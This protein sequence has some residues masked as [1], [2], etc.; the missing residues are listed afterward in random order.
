MDRLGNEVPGAPTPV[1]VPGVLVANPSTDEM[2]AARAAG[3]SLAYTLHFPKAFT[4]SLR[5]CTVLLPE[6]W[7]NEVGYR[8][9]GDPR[10]YMDGNTPGPWNRP[11][12]VVGADG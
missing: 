2:E 1:E 10:P 9:V 6:P 12:Q 5:G 11:V 3:I 8:V 4:G 7:E